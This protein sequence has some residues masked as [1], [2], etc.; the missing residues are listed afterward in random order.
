MSPRGGK[1]RWHVIAASGLGALAWAATARAQVACPV[2]V[3]SPGEPRWEAAAK[4][5]EQRTSGAEAAPRDCQSIEVTVLADGTA[6]LEFTTTEGR[7]A[8]RQL[9]NP[10]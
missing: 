1:S 6:R 7:R 4:D 8:D 2:R 5:A 3:V 9:Q 10:Q